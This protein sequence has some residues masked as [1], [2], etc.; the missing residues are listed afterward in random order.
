MNNDTP[1]PE[2]AKAI[3]DEGYRAGYSNGITDATAHEWGSTNN[4]TDRD[5]ERTWLES[6]A[7]KLAPQPQW[8]PIETAPRDGTEILVYRKDC[9]VLLARWIAL[10]E[11]LTDSEI[12]K[13]CLTSEEADEPDWFY[14]D[15]VAGGRLDGGTCTHWQ[16]LPQPPQP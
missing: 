15:F 2:Q 7:I 6:N 11:F 12:E 5:Q 3:F 10:S 14:A 1:Q 9:G 4:R 16:P 13:S 8:Q